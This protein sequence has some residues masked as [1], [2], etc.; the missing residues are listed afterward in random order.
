MQSKATTVARVLLGFVFFGLGSNGLLHFVP[1]PPGEGKA[2]AFIGGLAASGYFFPL[3]FV[4]YLFSGGALMIGRFVPLALIV[5]AP[6]IVN[7]AVMHLVL[8]SSGAEM[9]LAM[10]VT[11]LEIFL[12]WCYRSAFRQLVQA[13]HELNWAG[14]NSSGTGGQRGRE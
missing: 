1:L 9:C 6:I 4:T 5:L 12:A 7:I 11:I 14:Q 10:L 13:R 2:A 3:L 8:P